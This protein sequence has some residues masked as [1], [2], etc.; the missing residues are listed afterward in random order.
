MKDG[1][2]IKLIVA[3]D[4]K[5]LMGYDGKIP[6]YNSVDIKR[7]RAKTVDSTVVMGRRTWS[8]IGRP[9][10]K[11]ENIVVSNSLT[12]ALPEG[13]AGARSIVEAI[14]KSHNPTVWLIGGAGIYREAMENRLV[15]EI[16]HTTID[17][18]ISVGEGDSEAQKRERT[19]LFPSIPA[20]Y[21]LYREERNEEDPSLIH[22][23][24]R[25]KNDSYMKKDS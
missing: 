22:R 4:I 1:K 19:V 9:L 16:D 8:S 21:R 12:L 18:I 17:K 15:D 14:D 7:F 5:G 25:I 24:Y 13:V 23:T 6:W 20:V 10:P 11:R 2:T 3:T